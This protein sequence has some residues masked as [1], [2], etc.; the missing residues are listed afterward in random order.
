MFTVVVEVW[1]RISF[2]DWDERLDGVY[3]I[4]LAIIFRI[5]LRFICF[6]HDRK[7]VDKFLPKHCFHSFA[8]DI[9]KLNQGTWFRLIPN[10]HNKK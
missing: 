5:A 2:W 7:S 4:I 1:F 3:D 10:F 9:M 8:G 6:A